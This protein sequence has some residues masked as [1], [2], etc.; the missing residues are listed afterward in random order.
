M[1]LYCLV[2][3][4]SPICVFMLAARSLLLRG[5]RRQK[6]VFFSFFFENNKDYDRLHTITAY[7]L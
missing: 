3:P 5:A 2:K 1:S 7:R 4:S 6:S